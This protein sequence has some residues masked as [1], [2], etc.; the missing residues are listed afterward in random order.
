[1][2]ELFLFLAL[3]LSLGLNALQLHLH[4]RE[5][6]GLLIKIMAKNLAEAEYYEKEYSKDVK[7]KEKKI[8]EI[9]GKRMSPLDIEKAQKAGEY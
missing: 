3:I 2:G 9:A 1:M 6:K 5:K 8:K 7:T 4:Y